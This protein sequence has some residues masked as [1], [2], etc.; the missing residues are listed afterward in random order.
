MSRPGSHQSISGIRASSASAKAPNP[1]AHP[2]EDIAD[3]VR[4][5]QILDYVLARRAVLE[6]SLIHI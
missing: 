5:R 3:P 2:A 1:V 6:L 4:P